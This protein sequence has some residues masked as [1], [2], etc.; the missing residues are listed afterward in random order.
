M[1][2]CVPETKKKRCAIH[3][4]GHY[5]SRDNCS[6]VTFVFFFLFARTAASVWSTVLYLHMP[7]A[8]PRRMRNAVPS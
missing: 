7:R 8:F 4:F 5:Y 2:Q 3:F 1:H 6:G